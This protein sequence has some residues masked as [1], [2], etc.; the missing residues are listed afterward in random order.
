MFQNKSVYEFH[1]RLTILK[2][3]A[4]AA[5]E[6]RYENANQ[7]ILPLNDCALEAFICGLPVKMSAKIG[8]RNPMTLE[9]AFGYHSPT[10]SDL[11]CHLTNDN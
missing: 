6:N 11:Y 10:F 1:D 8:A 9:T 2:S 7:M 4:Q 3:G 5:L